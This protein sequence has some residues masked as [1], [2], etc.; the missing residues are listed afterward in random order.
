MILPY[1]SVQ[2]QSTQT[3][4]VIQVTQRL[5]S[6]PGKFLAKPLE[7][8]EGAIEALSGDPLRGVKE[9]LNT[10]VVASRK[11]YNVATKNLNLPEP[12]EE[13]ASLSEQEKRRRARAE[14]GRLIQSSDIDPEIPERF[15]KSQ[16]EAL[17][18]RAAIRVQQVASR[19][20][21]NKGRQ[22]IKRDEEACHEVNLAKGKQE[23]R[24]RQERAIRARVE[25]MK[26]VYGAQ[27]D[28]AGILE[29]SVEPTKKY[30]ETRGAQAEA[31][32]ALVAAQPKV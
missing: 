5:P 13:W 6:E 32:E 21:Q 10:F 27:E 4:T 22:A 17:L 8:I 29:R 11:F 18:A 7:A 12:L 1:P 14:T 28:I 15:L 26:T 24:E 23:N 16:A 3:E 31:I 25:T 20:M 19:R 2:D 9:S 30:A